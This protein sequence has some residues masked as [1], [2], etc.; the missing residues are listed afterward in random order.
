MLRDEGLVSTRREGRNIYY[1]TN[2]PQALAVMTLLY[3]QFCG[4][5]KGKKG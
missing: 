1:S 2:S 4:K 5:S 3:Q